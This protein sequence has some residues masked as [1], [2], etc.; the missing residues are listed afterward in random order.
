M[1][2]LVSLAYWALI[3]LTCPVFFAGAVVVWLV[4]LPF[5]RRRVALHLYSCA[6]A[7]FYVAI[8]PFWRLEVTG[9][10]NGLIAT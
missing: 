5:D 10:Q 4:T 9:R 2:R 3:V 1:L 6:W 7:V 8:N